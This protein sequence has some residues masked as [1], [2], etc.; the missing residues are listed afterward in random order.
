M[1]FLYFTQE[2]LEKSIEIF[3][4]WDVYWILFEAVCFDNIL[5]HFFLFSSSRR[6]IPDWRSLFTIYHILFGFLQ[7]F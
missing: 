5:F 6:A 2:S 1:K 7:Y 4:N 3:P